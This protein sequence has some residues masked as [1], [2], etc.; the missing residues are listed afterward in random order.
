M[1]HPALG[2]FAVE[3]D[4][5]VMQTVDSAAEEAVFGAS[6]TVSGLAA[7]DHVVRIVPVSG[8]VAID[9]FV[10]EGAG[11]VPVEPTPTPTEV[12]TDRV[13]PTAE[14][15]LT[16]LPTATPA[17]I[18]DTIESDDARVVQSGLWTLTPGD[19]ASGGA[20]LFSSGSVDDTLALAFT[21]PRV[22]VVYVKHPALGTFTIEVDGAVLY[23]V[24]SAA[25]E[26]SSAR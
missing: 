10:V 18:L 16:P 22:D 6:V 9:A 13:T 7:G 20:T 8:T 4:G 17:E 26:A 21:G 19:L 11:G 5:A 12:D 23:T 24:N 25:T 3:I 14:P 15:T 2:V 1:Q